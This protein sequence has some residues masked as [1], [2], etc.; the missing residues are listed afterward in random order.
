MIAKFVLI[1]IV[2]SS[3]GMN[4]ADF[5]DKPSDSM[6]ECEEKKVAFLKRIKR[7][8]DSSHFFI[9]TCSAPKGLHTTDV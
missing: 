8:F 9:A 4:Y 6:R 1:V 7:R 3:D 2:I 5:V